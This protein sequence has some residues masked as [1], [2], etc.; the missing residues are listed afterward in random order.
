MSDYWSIR[1]M[2]AETRRQIRF[3]ASRTG[4]TNAEVIGYLVFAGYRQMELSEPDLA[5]VAM[6]NL[7]RSSGVP[8]PDL[9]VE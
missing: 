4:T 1:D 3:F 7:A 5:R 8:D 2:P 6:S 9:E